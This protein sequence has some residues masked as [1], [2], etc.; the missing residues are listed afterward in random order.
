MKVDELAARVRNH[1]SSRWNG[2]DSPQDVVRDLLRQE[3]AQLEEE[4]QQEAENAEKRAELR[5]DLGL[6]ADEELH[7]EEATDDVA[8]RQAELQRDILGEER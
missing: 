1:D 7:T 5:A 6:P 8:A 2:E 4:G 3:M